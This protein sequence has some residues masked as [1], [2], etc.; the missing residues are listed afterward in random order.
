MILAPSFLNKEY[1]SEANKKYFIQ[2]IVYNGTTELFVDG[3]KF[4][5]FKDQDPLI[6]GYFEIRTTKSNQEVDD[7]RV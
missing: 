2:I 6:E 3:K 5:S 4:F 1:L 7:F